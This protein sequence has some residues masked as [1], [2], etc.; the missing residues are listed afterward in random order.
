M[1]ILCLKE[2]LTFK[3]N[4]IWEWLT[5]HSWTAIDFIELNVEF[6]DDVLFE[7]FNL[8]DMSFNLF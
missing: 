8:S 2:E 3:S 5:I 1:G 4:A 7:F 6:K